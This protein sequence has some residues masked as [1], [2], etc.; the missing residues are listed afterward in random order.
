[1]SM[2]QWWNDTIRG[3]S[4]YSDRKLSQCH[5][6]SKI[7]HTTSRNFTQT[8]TVRRAIKFL[9]HAMAHCS[10]FLKASNILFCK[11]SPVIC[12]IRPP[13]AAVY[14]DYLP[15]AE[16]LLK[17]MHDSKY[18]TLW[19]GCRQHNSSKWMNHY[20]AQRRL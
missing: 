4:Q 17:A 7:P 13:T 20:Q 5:Y 19:A 11:D 18:C 12:L 8:S 9:S 1:M 10:H 14:V 6:L 3:K 16:F 2:E 15:S